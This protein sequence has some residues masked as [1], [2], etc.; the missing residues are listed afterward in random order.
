MKKKCKFCN[1]LIKSSFSVYNYHIA[2]SSGRFYVCESCKIMYQ[3]KLIKN[4]YNNQESSNYNLNK[5][6][7]YYLKQIILLNFIFNL[8]K[9]FYKKKIF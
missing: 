3:P 4:L 6:F 9:F 2:E 8:K 5:N 7:F 1:N